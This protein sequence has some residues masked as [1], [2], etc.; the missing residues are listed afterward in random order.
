MKGLHD[1]VSERDGYFVVRFAKGFEIYKN[2]IT[3]ST[4]C[5]IIG[6]VGQAGLDRANREIDRRLAAAALLE[7][8]NPAPQP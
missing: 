4:R 7:R 8:T 5:A 1:I 3:H 6:F 2:D